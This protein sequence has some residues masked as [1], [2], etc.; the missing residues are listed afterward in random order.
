MPDIEIVKLKLRRGTDAQRQAVT[1]EQ[2]ELGYTTDAKR[3]WVGDGF[4]VG[5]NNIGNVIHTPMYVGTRTDLTDAVNGD[6]VYED[7]LLYQLSG[8]YA[9]NLTSWA[10]IGTRPDD[11]TL[12]YT[13]SNTLNIANNGVGIAQL[14]SNVVDLSG[15]LAYGSTGLSAR[16]DNSSITI[17]ANG[18]LETTHVNI[19]AGDIGLGLSG[20]GGDQIGVDVTEAF[21]FTGGKLDFAAAGTNTVDGDAIQSAALGTGLQKSGSTIA[22]ETIGGGTASPFFTSEFDS[23]GR[24]TSSTNAIEQ[25]LSG[26]DTSGNGQIFFGSLNESNPG[27]TGETVINALSANSDRSASVAIALSSAGFIQ[28]ASGANGNFAIPVFKF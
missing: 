8:T 3:V 21:T 7:N 1:L 26:T 6:I 4:T 14:S 10:F 27:A 15:G 11:L 23:T 28:I 17:N 22:L 5:G 19:S 18:E 12:E 25:N 9:A 13:A 2:G 16:I 24:I 20:G